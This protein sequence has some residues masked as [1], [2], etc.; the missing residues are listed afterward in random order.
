MPQY[1]IIVP[2]HNKRDDVLRCL[3]HLLQQERGGRSIEIIVIDDG[4][5]DGT[6]EAVSRFDA[7]EI[8]FRYVRLE[9]KG[10]ATARNAGIR[11]ASGEV[12]CM[13]D[14]DAI[15]LPG[16]FLALVRP[17]EDEPQV[18]GVEGKVVPVGDD[19]GPLGMSPR[20]LEGGVY[21]TCNIAYRRDDLLAVGGFDEGFPF[22]AF[23][24]TDLALMMEARGK[25][26]WAPDA[27]VHHP[28]RRWSMKRALREVRFNR[29]LLRFALRHRCLGWR[30]RPTAWPRLRIYVAAVV[31]LPI[32]RA[33]SGLRW[34]GRDP[35]GAL[36]YIG[37]SLGQGVAASVM[38]LPDLI[39]SI[40]PAPERVSSLRRESP[41]PAGRIGEKNLHA[42]KP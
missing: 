27:E 7:G 29:A 2:T 24:D 20:N 42:A 12:V 40:G 41:S 10:P 14:D 16:W 33:I 17:F 21:L 35:M 31:T 36:R 39:A 25:L 3:E 9:G 5:R 11:A 34:L 37:I 19:H 1:S 32:G 13:I 4:S 26:V 22:P 18:V 15:P 30:D 8:P 6:Q 38:L 23:E 28:R